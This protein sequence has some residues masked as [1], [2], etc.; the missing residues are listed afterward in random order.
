MEIAGI[1]AKIEANIESL[2]SIYGFIAPYPTEIQKQDWAGLLNRKIQGILN[3]TIDPF[4][5]YNRLMVEQASTFRP[6]FQMGLGLII[7]AWIL[8]QFG[9]LERYTPTMKRAGHGLALG[10]ALSA[11]TYPPN[12]PHSSLNPRSSNPY[13]GKW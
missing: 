8:E 2:A 13:E 3:P 10:S 4:K 6:I 9:L 7:L 12:N 5:L 1:F 11:I